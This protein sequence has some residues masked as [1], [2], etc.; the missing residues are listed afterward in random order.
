MSRRLGSHQFFLTVQCWIVM[1]VLTF[2]VDLTQNI[3]L[4]S[5]WCNSPASGPGPPHSRGFL[6]H[7]QRHATF[8]RTPLDEWWARRRALYLITHNTH[9]RQ[10]FHTSGGIRTHDL[11]RL[12]AAD[13]HLRPRGHLDR[14][15]HRL[16][17]RQK[18]V[19]NL[20]VCGENRFWLDC[21]KYGVISVDVL[22]KIMINLRVVD[23]SAE[24]GT[25][26]CSNL[27]RIDCVYFILIIS[28]HVPCVFHCFVLWP[29]NAHNY[30]TN[31]H[32]A[33]CFDTI[34]SSSGSL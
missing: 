14:L 7:T 22:R 19:M 24:I 8:G 30:F 10:T 20:K 1:S 5:I 4:F 34:V 6:D 32:T 25:Q 31:C 13:P 17:I 23:G 15:G 18:W 29:T 2:A 9:N 33:T 12:A 16:I 3:G 21:K 11:S 27:L 26:V 28:I